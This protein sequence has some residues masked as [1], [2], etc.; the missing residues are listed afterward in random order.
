MLMLKGDPWEN[1][2]L[3][4]RGKIR[5]EEAKT[6]P[7]KDTI[8][9]LQ[10][11]IKPLEDKYK[12]KKAPPDC[13]F[14]AKH[15]Y[16]CE[17][18]WQANV[19]EW[20]KT[21]PG[22]IQMNA[23]MVLREI[24]DLAFVEQM[25]DQYGVAA[26]RDRWLK[27]VRDRWKEGGKE[28]K[29][30]KDTDLPGVQMQKMQIETYGQD[31][32]NRVEM[33]RALG[34]L[35]A[36]AKFPKARQEIL[37]SLT[38]AGDPSMMVKA[39]E[40]AYLADYDEATLKRLIELRSTAASYM[41]VN[42][43]KMQVR[44]FFWGKVTKG[45]CPDAAEAAE[46]EFKKCLNDPPKLPGEKEVKDANWN[47]FEKFKPMWLAEFLHAIGY[48][49][50]SDTKNLVQPFCQKTDRWWNGAKK[51][52]EAKAAQGGDAGNEAKLR[53]FACQPNPT[54]QQ[55]KKNLTFK[56]GVWSKCDAATSFLCLDGHWQIRQQFHRHASLLTTHEHADVL[57]A[58]TADTIMTPHTLSTKN[59]PEKD[60]SA[61]Y[62]ADDAQ[63]LGYQIWDETIEKARIARAR[64][65]LEKDLCFDR[66]F[67]RVAKK[68][69]ENLDCYVSVV[70]GSQDMLLETEDCDNLVA[71]FKIDESKRLAPDW[72]AK[73][74]ALRMLAHYGQKAGA[75][76]P[77]V[78]A[79]LKA[80]VYF[81][82][83]AQ[84]L[85][86][87]QLDETREMVLLFLDR[88]GDYKA[89]KDVMC[90]FPYKERTRNQVREKYNLP[91]Y[92][93]KLATAK[94]D[95]N[96]K[97]IDKYTGEIKKYQPKVD[98][99]VAEATKDQ[100]CFKIF[101][102]II[103]DETTRAVKGSWQI[104]RDARNAIGR[105]ARRAGLRYDEI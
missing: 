89:Q 68:C 87:D 15:K 69:K 14:P 64:E 30:M 60:K 67:L 71:P 2:I 90:E 7:N 20:S 78:Q 38:W 3:A 92:E 93:E 19:E 6:T 62:D 21:E 33:L 59:L 103:E 55:L 65:I 8:K 46:G 54:P 42:F 97:I 13:P 58:D 73:L 51:D 84:S 57:L 28:L 53:L 32:N 10:A 23:L 72:R 47:C 50:E 26:V 12:L 39:G 45:T 105:L 44:M 83:E 98:K 101:K 34:R 77:G 81:Y 66:R 40:G 76:S 41:M 31:M 27:Q 88:V 36:P 48:H 102:L 16:V 74:K 91:Q 17:L 9:N 63:Y 94:K 99:E 82:N 85:A 96:Q 35:N 24:G 100:P 95:N 22:V 11:E 80:A 25:I 52:L 29:D 4:T 43:K 37:D 61:F 56:C 5:D 75:S 18:F 79:A 49:K 104:N 86:Q 70:R 1:Q